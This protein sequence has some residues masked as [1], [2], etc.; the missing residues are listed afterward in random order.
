[1]KNTDTFSYFSSANKHLLLKKEGSCEIIHADYS[2]KPQ[3][4]NQPTPPKQKQN[5]KKKPKDPATATWI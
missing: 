5:P 2:K 1:M 3:P 4:I